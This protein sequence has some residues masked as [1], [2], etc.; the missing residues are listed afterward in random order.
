M[1]DEHLCEFRDKLT[2]S[3]G[4]ELAVRKDNDRLRRVTE[5]LTTALRR[6]EAM[7]DSPARYDS[8]IQ[9]VIDSA[10]EQSA[11]AA[12]TIESAP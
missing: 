4:R 6:I 2:E 8:D 11:Q 10:L 3:L 5:K 12:L 7:I 9:A 1:S